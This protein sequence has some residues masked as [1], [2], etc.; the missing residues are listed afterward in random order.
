MKK[1]VIGVSVAVVAVVIA[2]MAVLRHDPYR[3]HAPMRQAWAEDAITA[4]TS[5]VADVAWLTTE[6]AAL[7]AASAQESPEREDWLYWGS[8]ALLLMKNGDWI[9]YRN[10]CWKE[11]PRVH[12]IFIGRGSDGKWYYSTFHF[13]VGMC[14]LGVLAAEQP[15]D[16]TAFVSTYSLR[17]FDG[18]P[19]GCLELTWPHS[20]R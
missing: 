9:V 5:N 13:C 2:G 15:T 10:R 16:L 14:A 12:D 17:E 6:T 7:Q 20:G 4:I 1:W 11:D 19:E 18:R 8:D 3:L